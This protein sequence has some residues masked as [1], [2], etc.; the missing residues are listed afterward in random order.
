MPD[1]LCLV[2]QRGDEMRM[3]MAERIDGD[4]GGE[5]EI[6]LPVLR[7]QPDALAAFE[8]QGARI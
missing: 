2:L 7:D 1:L 5:I 3:G 6:A 8:P 4:A